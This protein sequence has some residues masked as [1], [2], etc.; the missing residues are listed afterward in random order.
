MIRKM[1]QAVL[2][3]ILSPL[4][5]AQQI[6]PPVNAPTESKKPIVVKKK[7]FIKLLILETV[8]SATATNG[9]PVRMVVKEDVLIDGAVAISK[10]TP[11]TGIVAG[12]RKAVPG[13]KDGSVTIKPESV[14][15]PNS[16]PIA[17]RHYNYT[18]EDDAMCSG[19]LNCLPLVVGAYVYGAGDL[20]AYP[21]RKHQVT[22]EDEV[23]PACSEAWSVVAR[24]I[25]IRVSG[26][27]PIQPA[28]PDIDL[29]TACPGGAK[30]FIS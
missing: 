15:L 14:R 30:A 1:L 27:T 26:T 2:C 18:L 4:L 11:A 9:Q 28:N 12:V 5:M 6:A 19:F 13:K 24:S 20:I 7:T 8:S 3:L 16:K 29:D 17:L 10:S 23:L 21:F 22:G 25:V